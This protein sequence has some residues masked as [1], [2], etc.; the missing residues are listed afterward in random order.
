[1]VQEERSLTLRL[2]AVFFLFVA[3]L[4]FNEASIT[5]YAVVEGT[6]TSPASFYSLFGFTFLGLAVLGLYLHSHHN[7]PKNKRRNFLH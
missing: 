2:L 5:G 7:H 1:M 4:Y 6:S 3:V